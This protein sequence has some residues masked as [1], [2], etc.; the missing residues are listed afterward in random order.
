MYNCTTVYRTGY[1]MMTSFIEMTNYGVFLR[2]ETRIEV[3]NVKVHVFY[4][5]TLLLPRAHVKVLKAA[6]A[7]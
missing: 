7:H 2:L 1:R 6:L 4:A 3:L 5:I